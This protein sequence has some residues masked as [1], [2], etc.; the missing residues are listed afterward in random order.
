MKSWAW[1]LRR[2]FWNYFFAQ[3]PRERARLDGRTVLSYD[4]MKSSR[5]ST[6]VKG[7]QQCPNQIG[8]DRQLNRVNESFS[9]LTRFLVSKPF[10][11]LTISALVITGCA[12]YPVNAPL[13]AVDPQAGYRFHNVVPQTYSDDLLRALAF[14]GGSTRSAALSFGVLEELAKTEVGIE[15]GLRSAG[16]RHRLPLSRAG[17]FASRAH[18]SSQLRSLVSRQY[19]RAGPKAWQI[20]WSRAGACW[21]G[22]C[23]ACSGK[24]LPTAFVFHRLSCL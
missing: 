9:I 23:I 17:D 7:K 5:W 10:E 6:T 18:E 22:P 12:Y 13:T 20:H 19:W 1:L 8:L 24:R 14:S 4:W 11:T 3:L 2:W 16:C 15:E 21:H